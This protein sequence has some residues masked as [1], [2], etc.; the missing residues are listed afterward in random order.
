M[1]LDYKVVKLIRIIELIDNYL[2]LHYF[3][4]LYPN[5]IIPYIISVIF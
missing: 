3:Y 1:S 2:L 5:N 4:S